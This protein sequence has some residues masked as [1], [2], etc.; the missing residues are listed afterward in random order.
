MSLDLNAGSRNIPGNKFNPN[1]YTIDKI[2]L[3]K[4]SFINIIWVFLY[5]AQKQE[6]KYQKNSISMKLKIKNKAV[7]LEIRPT[8]QKK[9]F[10]ASAKIR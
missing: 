3:T 10:F 6:I 4:L 1:G 7:L 8:L 9:F 2:K 5:T